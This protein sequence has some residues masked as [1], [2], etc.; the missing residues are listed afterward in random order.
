MFA[1][2]QAGARDSVTEMSIAD[3]LATPD[4]Q[5]KLDG[6]VK[7]FFGETAHPAVLH[8]FGNFVANDKTNA[9]NKSSARACEWAFLSALLQFQSRAAK[10]GA[11]AVVDIHSYYKKEDVS[12]TTSIQCHDGFLLTGVALRG[13]F[14]T[15]AGH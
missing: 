13:N 2:S 15:I 9:V 3:A 6:S 5:Q 7:F 4:A 1:M 14:V 11:N 10:L 8:S 12:S